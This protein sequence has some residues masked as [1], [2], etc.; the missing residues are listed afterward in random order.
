[1]LGYNKNYTTLALNCMLKNLER[2]ISVLEVYRRD[3]EKNI[4][5]GK[6]IQNPIRVLVNAERYY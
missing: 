4:I 5:V 2:M 6:N 3:K 1:M